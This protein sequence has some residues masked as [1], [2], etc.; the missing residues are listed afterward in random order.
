MALRHAVLAVLLDGEYSGYQ[1]AK[2]FDTG[3]SNFWHALPQQLYAELTKLEQ[4]GLI[5]GRQVIQH[6]RPNKRLHTVTEAGRAELARFAAASSKPLVIRDDLLVKVYAVDHID[7]APVIAQLDDQATHAAAK[8][9][10]FD[11]MLPNLRADNRLGPY[12]TC[13]AGRRVQQEYHD[14]CLEAAALLRDRHPASVKE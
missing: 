12:L 13:L 9:A 10:I 11:Q 14:W 3:V 2:I 7:P 1:L 4:D 5:A 6:D 8:V